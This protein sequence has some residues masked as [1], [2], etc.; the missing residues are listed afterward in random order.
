MNVLIYALAAVV[1]GVLAIRAPL[2]DRRDPLRRAYAVLATT[3]SVA[4]FG[5]TLYLIPGL[6]PL[7]Y[8]NGAA[9]ALIPP[10]ALA[11]IEALFTQPGSPRSRWLP[12]LTVASPPVALAFVA[13]DWTFFRH[14]PRAAVPEVML[15]IYVF[16]GLGVCMLRLW[17]LHETTPRPVEKARIRYLLLLFCAAAGFSALEA[18]VRSFGTEEGS[19]LGILTRPV[20]LQGAFPPIGAIFASLYMYFLYQVITEQRVP[21]LG[22][23]LSR[24]TAVGIAASL[25]VG[26]DWL[27]VANLIGEY[28]VHGAFQALM[29]SMLFLIAYDPLRKQ[30]ELWMGN[31]FNR[32]GQR[33]QQTVR[34]IDEALTRVI[35]LAQLGNELQDR[36]LDSGRVTFAALY[37]WDEER[38]SYRLVHERGARDEPPL[39]QVARQPFTEG[40]SSGQRAWVR[41][42][43]ERVLRRDSR[44]AEEVRARLAVLKGMNA[45]V[46]LPFLS[47]DVVLGWLALRAEE[48]DEGF[49]EEEVAR[50]AQTAGR[51]AV[52]LENLHGFEKL[53][54]EHRLAALGTMAAGLAHEIRNP[55]AGI[56]GAAQYLQATREGPDAEMVQVIIDEVDRLSQVVSQFL[57]YARPYAVHAEAIAPATLVSRV[58]GILR[59]GPLPENITILEDLAP[60]LPI[61][62]ADPTKLNQVL[63][64]LC[65]NAIH[66][67]KDGGTL[68]LRVHVGERR[69][70]KAR[71]APALE[72][73]VEDTGTGISKENL[74]NLFVPFFTTRHEGTGLGLAISRR[75]LQAHDGELDV[76][77]NVGKGSVFTLRIPL[78]GE[79]GA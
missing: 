26:I 45:D 14:V 57:D 78:V 18:L 23:V 71:R 74:E 46:V 75:I 11:L 20:V 2:S 10:A 24:I 40:F 64:N 31:L 69:D 1:A 19:A 29:A 77:S 38:R 54:E 50:L 8:V 42:D 63:L 68:T 61:I 55:L 7:K 37:L 70:P 66:A 76:V 22:E 17:E 41:A 33:L 44:R 56:K 72:I 47:G 3:L 52:I 67:M 65:Q 16:G 51:A 4:Y 36:L 60:N 49:T 53:K 21:E 25:L 58:V 62:R 79:E 6:A 30:L 35:S 32:R 12:R 48:G 5:F 73:A 39:L 34:D 27:S 15:A 43:I 13:V 28:P 9:A 59:A